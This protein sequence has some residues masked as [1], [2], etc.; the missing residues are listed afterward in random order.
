MA[1]LY[2]RASYEV[3]VFV[4]NE[5]AIPFLAKVI[6]L[7]SNRSMDK[8]KTID[9]PL[10]VSDTFLP[11]MADLQTYLE[12]IWA[13]GVVTNNGPLVNEFEDTLKK[14]LGVKHAFFVANGTLALQLALKALGD[15][16]SVITS[17]F[18]AVPVLSAIQ[19]QN[20]KPVFVDIDKSSYNLDTSLLPDNLPD[21]T[22]AILPTHIY[23]CACDIDAV[24]AYARK[25]GIK[26]IYDASQAYGSKYKGREIMQHGDI[27]IFSTHAYKVLNTIEGGVIL[28]PHDDI[29]EKIYQMRFYGKNRDNRVVV[30][31]L[32]AK[33]NELNAAIGLCNLKYV[34]QVL[35][36]RKQLSI[37]YNELLDGL[38]LRTIEVPAYCD[39]NYSY[40]PIVLESEAACLKVKEALFN[41]QVL[42]RRLFYPALNT[43]NVY[44][45]KQEMPIA[46]DIACRVLC[47]PLIK[48]V[49]T[50]IQARI[51]GIIKRVI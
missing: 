37:A 41:E 11:P 32:N 3:K 16:G 33:N 40:Y 6:A 38:P 35:A 8:A 2:S 39:F 26:T 42:T 29:A 31:G 48:E 13:S 17:A 19:W 15:D 5:G 36:S 46:E 4:S 47:L 27:T 43:I 24:D 1:M 25:K 18:S 14:Q 49:T 23:G 51:A 7:G 45:E 28:T 22:R 50:D 10:Y 30:E 44:G 20:Y 34:D 21:D 9:Q 12:K